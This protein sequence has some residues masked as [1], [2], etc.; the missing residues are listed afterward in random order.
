MNNNQENP[1][2]NPQMRILNNLN[3]QHSFQSNPNEPLNVIPN[4]NPSEP[5][6]NLNNGNN[7]TQN[8]FINNQFNINNDSLNNPNTGFN[9]E[10]EEE[11]PMLK[12]NQNRFINTN[13]EL[14]TSTLES[15][16]VNGEYNNMPKIDYSTDPKVRQN[17][18]NIN[19][20]GAK[21][22]IKIGSEGKVFLVIVAILLAFIIVM[23]TIY[24]AIRNA[25]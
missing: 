11:N 10:F 17:I 24:D 13:E 21:N 25:R 23:P 12:L 18:E 22:T 9:N 2:N 20:Y 19:K 8:R 14:K 15:M 4:T 6:Q 3:N 16:N 7:Q 5:P 1:N